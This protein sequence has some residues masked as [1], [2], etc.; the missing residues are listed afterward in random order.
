MSYAVTQM[1]RILANF[2]RRG[3]VLSVDL[4]NAV[5]TV[6][7]DGEVVPELEWL[8]PRMGDDREWFAPSEGEYVV[9]LSPGGDLSQGV[10]LGAT[11]QDRFP[12][13]GN[14]ANPRTIY[15]DDTVIEYDK[16][17]HVLTIDC[18]AASGTVNIVCDKAIVNARSS[19]LFDTPEGTFTGNLTVQK[20]V[21][22]GGSL[23][24]TGKSTMSG[25]VDFTGGSVKHGG[26]EIGGGH[27]HNG[28]QTGTGNTGDVN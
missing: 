27:T 21:N 22:V 14:N 15:A 26:K 7:F 28:V 10:I 25:D 24:V 6:D 4:G 11:A 20:N 19:V 17:N 3:R 23:G 1:D 16:E 13:A 18:S 5:A 12:D 8:K 9:V 2:M